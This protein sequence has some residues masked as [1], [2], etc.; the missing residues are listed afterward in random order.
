[1]SRG[2]GRTLHSSPALFLL[3]GLGAAAACG[4]GDDSTANGDDQGCEQGALNCVCFANQTCFN[5]LVCGG[6]LCVPAADGSTSHGSGGGT[7]SSESSGGSAASSDGT[8]GTTTATTSAGA[9]SDTTSGTEEGGPVIVDFGTNVKSITEGELVRFTAT[10]TDPDGP[11]DIQGGSLK[12]A[13][14]EVTF[15]A[16]SDLGNGTYELNLDWYAIDQAIGVEFIGSDTLAFKAVFFDNDGKKGFATTSIELTCD[17][18]F[19]CEGH[20]VWEDK[21]N[22]GSCG[23]WCMIECVDGVCD[24][25]DSTT[26]EPGLCGWSDGGYY[27]CGY[28]GVDPRGTPIEC[29]PGLVES[30]PCRNTGLTVEGCCDALGVWFCDQG[31]VNFLAC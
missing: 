1:M 20:C 15:G 28:E 18:D 9:T 13:D 7:G 17:T 19:A 11:D 24:P 30:E 27:D 31:F 4:H 5:G 10:L 2:P 22:C 23:N 16:F 14:E 26:G 6:N 25:P 3:L 29:P 8:G 21:E 12:S